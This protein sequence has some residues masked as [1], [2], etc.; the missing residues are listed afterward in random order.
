MRIE[1][2]GF[3]GLFVIHPSVYHDSR[4]YFMET[5]N[6]KEYSDLGMPTGYVQDNQSHSL[7]NVIRGLHFQIPPFAQEKLV[8][9]VYGKVR[10]VVIDLR[11]SQPTYG[12]VFSID[13]SSDNHLQLLIPKGFAHGFS[14]LSDSAGL[15]YK[16]SEFYDPKS[17]AG[18][19]YNDPQLAIDWGIDMA[20]A[21]VSPKDAGLPRLFEIPYYF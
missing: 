7:K 18:I 8:R 12:K 4:G 1:E 11:Q 21:I 2:T 6:Q 17:D 5:F 14:V 19:C 9:V 13:L 15:F 16:C 20:S 10:D 3:T